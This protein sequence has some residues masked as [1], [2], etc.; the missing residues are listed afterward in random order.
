MANF[1]SQCDGT[2]VWVGYFRTFT[3]LQLFSP[4]LLCTCPAFF[5]PPPLV[6]LPFSTAIV[7]LQRGYTGCCRKFHLHTFHANQHD[8]IISPRN[9]RSCTIVQF[10][11]RV[12]RLYVLSSVACTLTSPR[13]GAFNSSGVGTPIS[14]SFSHLG[15]TAWSL[16]CL[17]RGCS[18]CHS[19]ARQNVIFLRLNGTEIQ[20]L[21]EGGGLRPKPH[22]RSSL[23]FPGTLSCENRDGL[24]SGRKW[25]AGARGGT[26]L[27]YRYQ[28]VYRNVI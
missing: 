21:L 1:S 7:A 9:H 8:R 25:K 14:T 4:T 10:I 13:E 23:L 17:S 20:F 18:I 22:W 2:N 5:H 3:I 12:L 27:G 6:C 26:L 19:K 24:G 16:F 11:H 28:K 15:V